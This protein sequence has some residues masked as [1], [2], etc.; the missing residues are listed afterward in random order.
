MHAISN[1]E[2]RNL[3]YGSLLCFGQDKGHSR[4]SF[5]KHEEIGRWNASISTPLLG[6]GY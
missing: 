6:L 2:V 1:V 5:G 4:K 3:A